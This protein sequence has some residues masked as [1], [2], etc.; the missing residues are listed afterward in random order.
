MEITPRKTLRTLRKFSANLYL[1]QTPAKKFVHRGTLPSPR[2][3]YIL[4]TLQTCV[5]ADHDEGIDRSKG[6]DHRRTVGV[7]G[8]VRGTAGYM[9]DS[10]PAIGRTDRD[11]STTTTITHRLKTSS[12]SSSV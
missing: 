1:N 2:P 9:G 4:T 11:C 7:S 12:I 8:A 3:V 10:W 5:E 6:E